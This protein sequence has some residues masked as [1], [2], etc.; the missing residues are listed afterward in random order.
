MLT[1]ALAT[2]PTVTAGQRAAVHGKKLT[3]RA[4]IA[5]DQPAAGTSDSGGR[6]ANASLFTTGSTMA[7]RSVSVSALAGL[8]AYAVVAAVG[9]S[10]HPLGPALEGFTQ[11]NTSSVT[12]RLLRA[13]LVMA[14]LSHST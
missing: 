14:S 5:P 13:P 3:F 12:R 2:A 11:A 4:N 7:P 10:S 9:L 8:G 6:W 1:R